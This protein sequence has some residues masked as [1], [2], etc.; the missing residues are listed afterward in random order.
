VSKIKTA[1][2]PGQTERSRGGL[3]AILLVV[4]VERSGF[5]Q[6]ALVQPTFAAFAESMLGSRTWSKREALALLY[7]AKEFRRRTVKN[8]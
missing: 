7:P 8:G 1:D 5:V 3:V 6:K 4:N 2:D